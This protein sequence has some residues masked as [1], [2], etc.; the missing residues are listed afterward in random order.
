[1]VEEREMDVEPCLLAVVPTV[2]GDT[3]GEDDS[4]ACKVEDL[5]TIELDQLGRILVFAAARD[6]GDIIWGLVVGPRRT[7]AGSQFPLYPLRLENKG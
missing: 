6:D 5:R 7:D 3:E 1:M 4:A 2:A